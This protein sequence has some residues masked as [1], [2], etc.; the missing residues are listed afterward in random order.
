MYKIRKLIAFVLVFTI[1]ISV[2]TPFTKIQAASA[3]PISGGI[4]S[5]KELVNDLNELEY[6]YEEDGV[7]YKVVE[8]FDENYEG[9]SSKIYVK[10]K[11]NN[12]ILQEKQRTDLVGDSLVVETN[13]GG[14][15]TTESLKIDDIL[16]EEGSDLG[17]SL[18]NNELNAT[19]WKYQMT[20]KSSNF[21]AKLLVGSIA[22]VIVNFAKGKMTKVVTSIAALAFQMSISTIYFTKDWYYKYEGIIPVSEKMVTHVYANSARTLKMGGSITTIR[23]P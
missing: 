7:S 23:T 12:Y 15:V 10:D 2:L 20:T 11:S 19:G 17:V 22:I 6:S 8:K 16:S 21:I 5:F 18:Q 14:V 1:T 3:N 9:V 13:E 4:T